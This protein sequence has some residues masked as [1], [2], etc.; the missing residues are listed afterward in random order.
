MKYTKIFDVNKTV[1]K[2]DCAKV[3]Y[4]CLKLYTELYTG[5][6]QIKLNICTLLNAYKPYMKV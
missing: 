1:G 2:L 4:K 3:G 6:T 5:H